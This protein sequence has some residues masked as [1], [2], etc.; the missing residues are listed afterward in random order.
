[1][2]RL[3]FFPLVTLFLFTLPLI[4]QNTEEWLESFDEQVE[5]LR[6]PAEARS[7]AQLGWS[8]GLSAVRSQM[9]EEVLHTSNRWG[10]GL[11][12][13]LSGDFWISDRVAFRTGVDLHAMQ[14]RQNVDQQIVN[15]VGGGIVSASAMMLQYGI[16]FHLR[17]GPKSRVGPYFSV[18]GRLLG[19]LGTNTRAEITTGSRTEPRS[20]AAR[21]M[22][23]IGGPI[24][25]LEASVG[26]HNLSQQ[27]M[28]LCYI[29][30]VF[31]ATLGEVIRRPVQGGDVFAQ[32]YFQ[33][34]GMFYVSWRVGGYFG[35]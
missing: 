16:P 30:L 20:I 35:R 26:G 13:G 5:E 9:R 18:G 21:G 15:G 34:A 6:G 24:V 19:N 17:F 33:S 28:R 22:E 31:G 4:A 27:N 12:G 2:C 29:D 3:S 1:M 7:P 32:D 23:V 8:L 10:L 14:I 25:A 11:S